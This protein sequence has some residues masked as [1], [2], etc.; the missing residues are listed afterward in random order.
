MVT[1]EIEDESRELIDLAER[2]GY[3]DPNRVLPVESFHA[4][5]NRV[6][7]QGELGVSRPN[8]DI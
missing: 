8:L 7:S 5:I 6:K 3:L 2:V 1:K 4:T